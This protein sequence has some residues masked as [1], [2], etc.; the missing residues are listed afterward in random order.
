MTADEGFCT[1]IV[2]GNECIEEFGEMLLARLPCPY[3][4]GE[5]AVTYQIVEEEDEEYG[6]I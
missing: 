4:G 3:C 2:F 1:D 5:I 6:A